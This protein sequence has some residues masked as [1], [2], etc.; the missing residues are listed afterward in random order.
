MT[1]RAVAGGASAAPVLTFYGSITT[2]SISGGVNVQTTITS[3]TVG[4]SSTGISL[5][6]GVITFTAPGKYLLTFTGRIS[7]TGSGPYAS[8]QVTLVSS[9]NCSMIGDLAGNG[10]GFGTALGGTGPFSGSGIITTTSANATTS[11]AINYSQVDCTSS[12]CNILAV[13]QKLP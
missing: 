6:A 10:A 7:V 8:P 12:T 2:G 11:V 13:I 4:S 1:L 5:S 9:T 3:P